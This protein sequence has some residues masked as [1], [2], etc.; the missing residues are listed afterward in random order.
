[1]GNI[2][3]SRRSRINWLARG[4]FAPYVD[5]FKQYLADRGYAAS[6]AANYVGSVAHFAQW[7]RR[8]RLR[9]QGIDEAAVVEFLD[10]HLARCCCTGLVHRDRR[11]LS[12]A[13][14]HLLVVLRAQGAI[15]P[16]AARTTPVDEELRRYDEYMDHVRGLAPNTRAA[17]ASC[18]G[19]CSALRRRP[20]RH[21][22]GHARA[23]A[24]LLRA[25]GQALQQAASAGAWS[26]PCAAIS[27]TARQWGCGVPPDWRRPVSRQ[28]AAEHATQG[29]ECG[30][31]RATRAFVR[32]IRSSPA[33][34]R[35]DCALRLGSRT[36]RR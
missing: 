17:C 15:A 6:T 8:R 29:P 34:G 12:A 30:R 4:P 21:L 5:A 32:P 36:A 20:G 2:R 28:L 22:G 9:I 16:P 19:C 35:C 18:A 13:L 25:A 27:A 11:D 10:E 7:I 3:S 14:G 1:M 31:S 26:R 23:R 24:P 33:S